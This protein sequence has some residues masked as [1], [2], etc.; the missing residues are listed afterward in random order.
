MPMLRYPSGVQYLSS[1]RDS[2]TPTETAVIAEVP[3]AFGERAPSAARCRGWL[4]SA[5]SH[6]RLYPFVA[7]E[8]ITDDLI[9]T[10]AAA[11]R[12]G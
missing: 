10:L 8:T 1:V 4:G 2:R 11:V 12:F 9:T 3:A 5:G 6:H 7:P